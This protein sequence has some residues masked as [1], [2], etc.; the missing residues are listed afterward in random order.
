MSEIANIVA[1]I[2]AT[3]SFETVWFHVNHT[4]ADEIDGAPHGGV[5]LSDAQYVACA[6]VV[7]P[8]VT[9]VVIVT[10]DFLDADRITT[11]ALYYDGKEWTEDAAVWEPVTWTAD[12]VRAIE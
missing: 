3:Y 11:R 6:E 7:D 12:A 9:R 10:Q 2:E 8:R 5:D 4:T 1:R